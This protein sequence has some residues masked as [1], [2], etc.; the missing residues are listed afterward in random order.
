M[1]PRRRVIAAL[2]TLV[3]L[4]SSTGAI[5]ACPVAAF[6]GTQLCNPE[7]N[8]LFELATGSGISDGPVMPTINDGCNKPKVPT[9]VAFRMPCVLAKSIGLVES[10]WRQFNASCG[11]SGPTIVSFDCGY[12]IMQITSGMSGGAGFDPTRVAKEASYNIATGLK[13]MGGKWAATP[14]VGDNEVDVMEDWYYA[15]WA[16]NGFCYCNNPNNPKFASPRP[17][18]NGPG[19][20]ARANYPY[21]EIVWGVVQYPYA[22][23]YSGQ[24]ISYPSNAAIGS[25]PAAIAAPTPTHSGACGPVVVA[26]PDLYPSV[27]I[28]GANDRFADA[29]SQGKPDVVEEQGFTAQLYVKNQGDAVASDVLVGGWIEEPFI[30]A[31]GYEIGSDWN[32]PGQFTVNDANDHPENPP[33]GAP[34]GQSFTLHLYALSPGETKRITLD[35]IAKNYSIGLADH[36]DVRLWVKDVP[37]FYHQDD[38]D[39][40]PTE[41]KL[42]TFGSQ[43]R[44]YAQLDVY[45]QVYW[46]W[47]ADL[48]EGWQGANAAT[49][50]VDLDEHA[51][52]ISADGGQDPQAI[53]PTVG[54]SAATYPGLRLRAKRTGGTGTTRVYFTTDQ[55]PSFDEAKAVDVGLAN[56]AGYQDITVAMTSNPKWTSTITQLR[57]DPFE[58]GSGEVLVDELRAID[59]I[60]G[61]EGPTGSGSTSTSTNTNTGNGGG[62]LGPSASGGSGGTWSDGHGG[63]GG[64]ATTGGYAQAQ[65]VADEDASGCA[66]TLP[67]RTTHADRNWLLTT[68]ALS[69][70]VLGRRRRALRRRSPAKRG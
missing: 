8:A 68:A 58:A 66:C 42:Q 30:L 31:S 5:A 44:A 19:T 45:S 10:S 37:G 41:N 67:T 69:A 54:F 33:H 14:C 48:L 2:T 56:G 9:K 39:S 70:W 1:I 38:F 26:H 49:L 7:S 20:L 22:N 34:L 35:M 65:G 47:N 6:N 18:Y 28:E 32:H 40:S 11:S 52:A 46:G 27:A 21:Q 51:L 17:P 36:P 15:V 50:S 55:E 64:S 59:A 60:P 13:M 43:L 57:F 25:T 23:T 62:G 63:A 3:G 4:L 53:G 16:Y 12:G 24:A 29:S 61:S